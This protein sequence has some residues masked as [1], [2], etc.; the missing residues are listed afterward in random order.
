MFAINLIR[1]SARTTNIEKSRGGPGLFSDLAQFLSTYGKA[2]SRRG[3]KKNQLG[4]SFDS[5][6]WA[7][8]SDTRNP[9]LGFFE[10]FGDCIAEP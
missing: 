5:K 6:Y 8:E 3:N 2:G 1:V 4:Y 7:G 10:C 9:E